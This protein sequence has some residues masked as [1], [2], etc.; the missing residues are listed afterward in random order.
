MSMPGSRGP[1]FFMSYREDG[2]KR[3]ARRLARFREVGRFDPSRSDLNHRTRSNATTD[4]R[5]E[6]LYDAEIGSI[7]DAIFVLDPDPG[8][9]LFRT[10]VSLQALYTRLRALLKHFR[11]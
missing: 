10:P 9:D 7:M 6:R 5:S 2:K 1:G 11:I 3:P 8:V 4:C